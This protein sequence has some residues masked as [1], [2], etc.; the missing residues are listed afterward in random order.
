M[1]TP[2][3]P[4]IKAQIMRF[5][6]VGATVWMINTAL[7][8][9]FVNLKI[10][11]FKPSESLGNWMLTNLPAWLHWDKT[12]VGE[13]RYVLWW[14]AALI[15]MFFSFWLNRAWTFGVQAKATRLKHMGRFYLV[16]ILGTVFNTLL[17]SWFAQAMGGSSTGGTGAKV[18]ILAQ[19]F[20]AVIVAFWNFAGQRLY[21]FRD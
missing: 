14:A 15:A 8:L 18:T 11:S 16:S 10:G 12:P 4:G 6:A 21:A 19:G 20:S 17:A 13:A 9:A 1:T 2:E 7:A 3:K 5:A